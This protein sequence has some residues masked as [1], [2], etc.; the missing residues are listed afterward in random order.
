MFVDVGERHTSGHVQKGPIDGVADTAANRRL[1]VDL[2]LVEISR[3]TGVGERRRAL[4]IRPFDVTFDAEDESTRLIVAA[5]ITAPLEPGW[6][7]SVG[8]SETRRQPG[9]SGHFTVEVTAPGI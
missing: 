2:R 3:G 6:S 7:G 8:G 1:A 4:H 5:Q 9:R